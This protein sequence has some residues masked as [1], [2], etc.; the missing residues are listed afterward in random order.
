MNRITV[1]GYRRG[2]GRF[3][4]RNHIVVLSCVSCVNSLVEQIARDEP[5]V[6]AIVHQ[7]GCT[8]VGI[9]LAQVRR[10][11][12]G[13]CH[14]PNVGGTLVIGLGCETIGATDIAGTAQRD[15]RLVRML[16]VQDDGRRERILR[17]ARKAIEEL[18]AFV[19]RQE[20][21]EFGVEDL[22]VALECGGSDPF[23]G[24][25]ANPA[26]GL[27]SDRLVE[28]GATVILSEVPEM[29]GAEAALE[30]RIPDPDVRRRLFARIRDYME[31]ARKMGSDLRGANPTPG[32]MRAGLSTIEEKSLGCISKSGLTPIRE[33]VCY[34]QCPTHKGLVVMD[35]PGNDAESVTGMVAGGAHVVLFTTGVGTPLG[36]AVAPVIKIAATSRTFAGMRDFMD[37]DAG[38]II[39]GTPME[40]VAGDILDFLVRVCRGAPTATE[41]NRCR[42]FAINRL[43]PSF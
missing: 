35:T 6:V 13:V 41:T 1:Q 24:I 5:D 34:A 4:I 19:A 38:R 2:E 9:D 28:L 15:G 3:G 43:G 42:E 11:L 22:V 30:G 37:I 16:V 39:T 14:H 12:A 27:V 26:V 8:H 25:T 29:I 21:V 7:H 20:V 31:A 36:N 32:N 23:S 17:E 10:T 18:R 33:F 40:A